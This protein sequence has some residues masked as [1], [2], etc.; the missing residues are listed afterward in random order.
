MS[1]PLL[2]IKDKSLKSIQRKHP[3]VFS[4]GVE[5]DLSAYTDGDKVLVANRKGKV[6]GTGH[7]GDRS[8]AVRLLSFGDALIDAEFYAQ[9]LQNA[10]ESRLQMNLPSE[11]TNG[12]RLVHGEGDQ[13]PGL[14]IDIYA[15]A[16]VVQTHSSGMARDFEIIKEALLGLSGVELETVVHISAENNQKETSADSIGGGIDFLENGHR[17]HSNWATG[18]KTGFFIDQRENR[19][20]LGSISK[21]KKV[22]NAFSY[23]GGF[24]VYALM[25]GASEVHSLDSS[26]KALELGEK[27]VAMNGLSEDRHKSIQADALKHIATEEMS[28]YDIVVLDPPAFAKHRSARHRAVQAYKRLNAKAMSKMKSGSI[29]MT[30]SCSQVVTPDL[31]E[32]TI[33]AAAMETRRSVRILKHLHQP[34]DHPTSIYHPEGEYLKGLALRID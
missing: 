29:L 5:S 28:E 2:T 21:G 27:H 24:S 9:K 1:Y 26:A 13:L 12:F 11:K 16:A 4:G 32:N 19:A 8:I 23:T 17:F 14:I 20:F 18:Q 3:W 34:A 33:A 7:F 25:A 31:F 30:F 15:T 22:L 10:L 6:L